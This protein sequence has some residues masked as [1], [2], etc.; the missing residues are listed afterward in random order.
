[1]TMARMGGLALGAVVM[2]LCA[3]SNEASKSPRLDLSTPDSAA[4]SWSDACAAQDQRALAACVY[5]PH[6]DQWMGSVFGSGSGTGALRWIRDG[7]ISKKDLEVLA[8]KYG[9]RKSRGGDTNEYWARVST[10]TE[11]RSDGEG[12]VLLVR[13]ADGWRV[14]DLPMFPSKL[15]DARRHVPPAGAA[16][17]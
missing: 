7:S 11:S 4:N 8:K 6:L 14:V 15:P 10:W 3:C 2:A 13:L 17:R 16:G 1:M 9:N 5:P 12:H